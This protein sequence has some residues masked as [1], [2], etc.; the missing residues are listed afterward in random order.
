MMISMRNS[1]WQLPPM[2]LDRLQYAAANDTAY[3]GK[4]RTIIEDVAPL[5]VITQKMLDAVSIANAGAK[6]WVVTESVRIDVRSK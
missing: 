6:P 2:V 5:G 3:I 4:A 1:N